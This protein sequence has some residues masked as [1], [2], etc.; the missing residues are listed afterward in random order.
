MHTDTYVAILTSIRSQPGECVG[1]KQGVLKASLLGCTADKNFRCTSTDPCLAWSFYGVPSRVKG[2]AHGHPESYD[3][4]HN[5]ALDGVDCSA[6]LRL[7]LHKGGDATPV[8]DFW[9]SA[10]FA[11]GER[12]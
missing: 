2:L 4:A 6:A 3:P 10:W 1:A 8:L 5:E 7:A 12:R 9:R 11:G